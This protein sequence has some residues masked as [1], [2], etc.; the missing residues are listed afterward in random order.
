MEL[1][2]P[3]SKADAQAGAQGLSTAAK[4]AQALAAILSSSN[5]PTEGIETVATDLAPT[6]SQLEPSEAVASAINAN[7]SASAV[8][9]ELSSPSQSAFWRI[10]ADGSIRWS[11]D[12][13]KWELQHRGPKAQLRVGG[14]SSAFTCWLGGRHG[15]ILKSID[16]TSWEKVR[17]PTEADIIGLK[18]RSAYAA[19]ITTISGRRFK[20]VD[21]GKSWLPLGRRI[22]RRTKLGSTGSGKGTS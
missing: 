5:G 8:G 14:A 2:V 16:G 18:V 4:A 1:R 21:G 3:S 9:F 6:L 22:H 15:A 12:G 13:E 19:T 10:G 20:T 7:S 11:H 17:S